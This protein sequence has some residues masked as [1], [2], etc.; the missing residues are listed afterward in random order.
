MPALWVTCYRSITNPAALAR[1]AELGVPAVLNGGGLFIARGNASAIFEC[2]TSA[3]SQRTVVIQFPSVD[4]AVATYNSA[5]YR[6]ALAALGDGA[7][8]DLRIVE[9]T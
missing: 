3:T 1:Y 9:M 7:E 5:A 6:E 2:A 4:A 8:R